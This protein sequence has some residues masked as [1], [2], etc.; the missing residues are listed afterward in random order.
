MVHANHAQAR[1]NIDRS[2]SSEH[3]GQPPTSQAP[4]SNEANK[5]KT[6]THQR[7]M[8]KSFPAHIE[9]A[10]RS[11]GR[12]RAE[13]YGRKSTPYFF[14]S[15][16]VRFSDFP[17]FAAFL[18]PRPSFVENSSLTGAHTT[19]RAQPYTH[20]ERSEPHAE[21]EIVLLGVWEN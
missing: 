12:T 1:K 9:L 15:P 3:P 13:K 18:S 17:S 6:H 8:E 11:S 2:T 14:F 21:W 5:K 19:T 16:V 4:P 10:E 7:K 20:L